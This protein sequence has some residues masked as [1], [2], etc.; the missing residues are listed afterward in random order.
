MNYDI[1]ILGGGPAGTAAAI[2]AARAGLRVAL[3]ESGEFPRHKVCGEF[4]SAESLELL[5]ELL[6]SLA[7]APAALG[8]VPAVDRA[9]LFL[10]DRRVESPIRPPAR[11]IPRYQLDAL[12]CEAARASG[13]EVLCNCEALGI[14]GSGPFHIVTKH[15]DFTACA[16]VVATGRWSRFSGKPDPPAQRRAASESAKAMLSGGPKW[17]GLKAHFG[18]ESPSPTT[19]LYFFERGYCGVQPVS[20]NAVNACAM[21]RPDRATSLGE[22]FS[23]HPRLEERARNWQPLMDPVS[24]APLMF[25]K[26]EPVSGN[27]I[28]IGDAA[29]F[30]DPFVGDG[31]SIALRTGNLA[32][33]CLV[34]H[35]GT[36]TPLADAVSQYA[37]IYHSQ[38]APLLSASTRVRQILQLPALF[39]A[40]AFEFMSL[41]GLLPYIIRKTRNAD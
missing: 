5:G 24:T 10:G 11:S 30:I 8:S 32:A 29:A 28:R 37:E 40:A 21:V 39:R 4:V 15:A 22:V 41:P 25:R 27:L 16:V 34:A 20:R 26:P 7:D 38:V 2:T 14:D 1:V 31:I 12:L 35:F 17:I 33:R 18:E 13:A 6:S 23:L 36:L 9:R 3:L 19:D